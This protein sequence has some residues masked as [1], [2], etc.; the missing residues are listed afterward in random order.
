MATYSTHFNLYLPAQ[1]DG[2]L[3]GHTWGLQINDNFEYIDS[4]ID[5]LTTGKVAFPTGGSSGQVLTW[6][7]S[8]VIWAAQPTGLPGGGTNGQ[9]LAFVSGSAEWVS[10][11]TLLPSG[12]SDGQ[13]LG[14]VSGEPAW[15]TPSGSGGGGGILYSAEFRPANPSIYDDEFEG[16]GPTWTRINTGVVANL[17]SSINGDAISSLYTSANSSNSYTM[18]CWLQP[19]PDGDFS[20]WCE[21]TSND[22]GG[23]WNGLILSSTNTSGTGYQYV[24]GRVGYGGSIYSQGYT[25]SNFNSYGSGSTI[26]GSK[27]RYLRIRRSGTSYYAGASAD[28][29]IWHEMSFTPS[30]IPIYMGLC[31]SFQ[32]GTP[33]KNRFGFFR[34]NP[35][36]TA[37]LGG[38]G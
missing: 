3:N 24:F 20:I 29:L 9:I 7:P 2:I 30:A 26:S 36:A 6:D 1:G 31:I 16:T 18:E 23:F 5:A 13:V 38:M 28:G 8:G 15:I 17:I 35:S 37:A 33:N 34:Y 19:L 14:L 22:L 25:Y 10:P 11:S 12:G 27:N 32:G 21:Q 4:L